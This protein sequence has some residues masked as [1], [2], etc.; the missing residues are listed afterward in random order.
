[1]RSLSLL[2]SLATLTT[3]HFT[4]NYPPSLEGSSIDESK[5]P[6]APCGAIVPSLSST[7]SKYTVTDF[8]VDGDFISLHSGHPQYNWLF[9]ASV[10][11]VKE[12]NW[13]QLYPIVQQS[14]LG[15]LC[16]Q[17]VTAPKG[18]VGKKGVVGVVGG[19]GDGTL[20][21]CSVVNF[22]Q[23]TNSNK[24][25]SCTN[26]TG[27]TAAYT[28]DAELDKLVGDHVEAPVESPAPAPSGTSGDKSAGVVVRGGGL[29]ALGAAVVAGVM[30][31]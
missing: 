15:D 30:M 7:D 29:M 24:P 17:K 16:S 8:H 22:V 4:I 3:A 11:E 21:Q 20:F 27:V 2:L 6:N 10:Q 26:S 13:T 5:E 14:G 1:M 28:S 31:L 19:S 25:S 9:R 23:G 12:G 18:W